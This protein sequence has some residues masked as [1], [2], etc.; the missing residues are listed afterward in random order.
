MVQGYQSNQSSTAGGLDGFAHSRCVQRR[1]DVPTDAAKVFNDTRN[2]EICLVAVPRDTVGCCAPHVNIPSGYHVLHQRWYKNMGTTDPG[3]KWC[4]PFWYRV[5][6]VVNP[7]TI[8]YSAPS[9]QVP[10]AD[11]VMV[12]I[13]L[14]LTFSIGPNIEA[15]E[16]FV[17]KLGCVRFDEFL[18]AE[19]EEGIRG[20][21]YSVTHDCVNDLREEFAQGML[22]TL[23]RKFNAF[24]VTIKTVKITEVRLP[25]NLAETLEQTTTFKTKIGEVAKKHEN[26]VRVLQ[27][28]ASQELETVVRH[29]ARRKQDLEA[30]CTKYHYQNKEVLDEMTGKAAVSEMEAKSKAEVQVQA[31]QGDLEVAQAEGQKRAEEVRR[32]ME[33]ACDERKV[34]VDQ[35]AS[36][37]RLQSE[38]TRVAADNDSQALV[39]SAE[40]E[41]RSTAGLDSKRRYELEW[42]RLGV[43]GEFAKQGRRFITG[44]LA[45]AVMK[46]MVPEGK[47]FAPAKG[48][49]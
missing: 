25:R 46:E 31:A 27:D 24:G 11:N 17:Y 15:A 32:Q 5:S 2:N 38:A 12:D 22:A 10:T 7:A 33:I 40:A 16:A 26:T 43:L 9:Q 36:V 20:L 44:E 3:V 21:V 48:A 6:H 45:E 28:E 13:N 41:H 30:K 14:S 47:S 23:S 39:A 34:K 4:W 8:T 35:T 1:I 42:Q 19:A 37:M 18:A 49:F 29:Q